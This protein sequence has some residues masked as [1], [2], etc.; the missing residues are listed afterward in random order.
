MKPKKNLEKDEN[1]F[2]G[3]RNYAFML[4]CVLGGKDKGRH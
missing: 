1:V 3:K 2:H 4:L